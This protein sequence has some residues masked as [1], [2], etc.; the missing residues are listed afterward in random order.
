[1]DRTIQINSELILHVNRILI[2]LSYFGN[3][4]SIKTS[5]DKIMLFDFYMKY[6]SVMIDD[7]DL[8]NNFSYYDYYSYYHW[9]PNREEYHLYLRY[10]TAKRL[11]SRII[12][13]NEFIYQITQDGTDIIEGLNSSYSKSLKSVALHIKKHVSKL[14][15]TK[16]ENEIIKRSLSRINS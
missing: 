2:L 8:V 12:S 14:S 13:G 11:I 4:K 9:K 6:P 5:L 16:I 7:E 1:M 3:Q 10:L 15:D